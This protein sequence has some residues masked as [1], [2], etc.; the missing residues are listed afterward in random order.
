MTSSVIFCESILPGD[1]MTSGPCSKLQTFVP[2]VIVPHTITEDR[3]LLN[4][5]HRHPGRN[6]S[7]DFRHTYTRLPPPPSSKEYSS[8]Q[9]RR[10]QSFSVQCALS[11]HHLKRSFRCFSVRKGFFR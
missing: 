3:P 8:V 11:L 1:I 10:A 2:K 5:G 6:A 7:L 4:V 9:I